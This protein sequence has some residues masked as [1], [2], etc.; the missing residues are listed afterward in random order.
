MG[1]LTVALPFGTLPVRRSGRI[2]DLLWLS[3]RRCARLR[4]AAVMDEEI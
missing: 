4:H 3:G 2:L 1:I